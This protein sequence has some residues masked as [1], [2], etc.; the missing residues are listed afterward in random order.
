MKAVI[1]AAGRGSRLGPLTQELPK[2][3]A[4][5]LNGRTLLEAQ[6]DTLRACGIRDIAVVRGYRGGK[7][8]YPG[9]RYFTNAHYAHTNMLESLLCAR[10][11]LDGETIVSYGDIWYQP[12]V[13]KRLLRSDADV[14]LAVDLAWRQHYVGR[15]AHPITEAEAVV[16]SRRRDVI[17]IGKIAAD[18][19]VDGEFMGLMKLTRLGCALIR[20]HYDRARAAYDGRPFQR[21]SRFRQAYLTD[22]LQEMADRGVSLRCEA[23][24]GGWHEIDTAE[25]LARTVSALERR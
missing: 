1:L 13:V 2:C 9:L 7:I 21:A 14:A 10:A 12:D 24:R 6:V 23:M 3:L 11:V 8:R 20:D 25:D 19:E 5:V 16:M 4:V 22:L 15:R 18:A 17:R